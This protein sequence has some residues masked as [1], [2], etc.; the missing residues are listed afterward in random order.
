MM[1]DR[2]QLEILQQRAEILAQEIVDREQEESG[3]QILRFTLGNE[4]YAIET[5]YV[6]EIIPVAEITPL[7][8]IPPYIKGIMNV[9][10]KILSVIDL[11][12]FLGIQRA[13]PGEFRKVII[14]HLNDFDIG[15]LADSVPGLQTLSEELQ[16]KLSTIDSETKYLK[17]VTAD[18]IA[19]LD[20]ERLLSDPK[21]VVNEELEE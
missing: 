8:C 14:L 9:R 5:S 4:D 19:V 13:E 21:I 2:S 18:R 16:T 17:G 10:G 12:A 6:R 20:V 15:I 3:L 7:P 1:I 11:M